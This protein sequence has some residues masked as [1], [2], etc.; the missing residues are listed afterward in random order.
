MKKRL[1][2]IPF[3]ILLTAAVWSLGRGMFRYL[4]F[5]EALTLTN[6][7]MLKSWGKIYNSYII[8]NNQII[9]T[10]MLNFCS[11]FSSLFDDYVFGLRFFPFAV[12]LFMLV[13]LWRKRAGI[14]PALTALVMSQA[15]VIY[16][17][18]LRGYMLGAFFAVLALHFAFAFICRKNLKYFLGYFAMS[19]LAVGTI[20]TNLAVLGAVV[21]Y[22]L[23]FIGKGF[24]RDRRFWILAVTPFIA[25]IVFY[26]PIADKFIGCM[27]L[28]EGWGNGGMALLAVWSI[29]IVTFLP[30]LPFAFSGVRVWLKHQNIRW[31]F[32]VRLLIFLLPVPAC[33]LFPVAPFPR[34]FFPLFPFW[35]LLIAGA[36]RHWF[37]VFS[38]A[39][40][41]IYTVFLVLL[42]VGWGIFCGID[43]VRFAMSDRFGGGE[44]TDDF[45]APYYMRDSFDPAELLAGLKRRGFN[46]PCIFVSFDADSRAFLAAG[47]LYREWEDRIICDGPRRKVPYLPEGALIILRRD[48][49]IEPWEK[50]FGSPLKFIFEHGRNK[51]YIL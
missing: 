3:I 21:L 35:A 15:F 5:D 43:K 29:G 4:W 18:A 46:P 25:L 41:R 6:F 31:I 13:F 1:Q 47:T 39:K 12:S 19:V 33:L 17:T 10:F 36:L 7:A 45:F 22:L 40:R 34:T 11:R 20:P 14:L 37:A 9:H 50:R 28:K 24:Y 48:E 16:G 23:P 42:T 49:N 51:V 44:V 27:K 32:A 26:L 30:L 8:P 2:T 38:P